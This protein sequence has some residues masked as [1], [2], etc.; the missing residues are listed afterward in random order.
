MKL[1][2]AQNVLSDTMT[3]P[4]LQGHLYA[5]EEKLFHPDRMPDRTALIPLLAAEF[6]EFCPTGRVS[7][8]QQAIDDMLT[9]HPRA[10][11]IHHYFVIPLCD[12]AALATYRLTTPS[13][14]THRSSL[15]V[16]RENR[17]QLLFH[18]G[19]EAH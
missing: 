8:R 4:D 16:L 11:T 18:Q 5:L 14:I 2:D 6:Q 9:C 7:N 13:A 10:A 12:A 15:W 17:W 3:L 1:P 19:T